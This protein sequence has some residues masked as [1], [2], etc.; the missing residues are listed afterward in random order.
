M[1][2][3]PEFFEMLSAETGAEYDRLVSAL[4]LEPE[5]SVRFN[6][7]KTA[8]LPGWAPEADVVPWEPWGRYLRQRESFTIDPQFHQGFYYVQEASSM[9]IGE[10]V[11]RIAAENGGEPLTVLDTCAAPGGKTTALLAALPEGSAV[12]A[13]EYD[14]ERAEILRENLFK[15]GNPSVAVTRGDTAQFRKLRGCFDIILVDAPC[16]GEGMFRKDEGARAQWSPRLVSQ[17]AERQREIL[18][19]VVNALAPGGYLIYSTCTF[20]T[21]ENE[22]VV[23]DCCDR[24]GLRSVNP[25]FPEQWNISP[26]LNSTL[27][28]SRFFP[29]RLRGEGL[30]VAVM[31][32]D[33]SFTPH[34]ADVPKSRKIT[35]TESWTNGLVIEERDNV[36][37]GLTPALASLLNRVDKKIE[38]WLSRGVDIANVK[39]KDFIPAHPLA[40]ST[41]INRDA[42]NRFSVDRPTALMFLRRDNFILPTSV[43]QG[44][45]LLEYKGLPL[46]FVK[47]LGNRVNNLLPKEWRIRMK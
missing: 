31:Q 30:F 28:V 6:P 42:F 46:G 19:N 26:A 25:G 21:V 2:P 8:E 15:W 40:L 4:S 17:C 38:R 12:I 34:Q 3:K 43:P 23:E 20:N 24:Y 45:V 16:S 1:A 39:G 44:Y 5:V 9:I 11:R 37:R 36:I 10:I 22:Q 7:A 29:H 41:A 27:N 47:N 14:Y 32:R 33:G 13:N 18:S 35:Q